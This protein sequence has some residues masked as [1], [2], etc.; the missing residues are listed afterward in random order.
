MLC[1]L[2]ESKFEQMIRSSYTNNQP[3]Q[4]QPKEEEA[5]TRGIIIYQTE[6]NAPTSLRLEKRRNHNP[7][8]FIYSKKNFKRK[9][10]LAHSTATKLKTRT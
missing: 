1:C 5:V 7:Q 3:K 10:L 9:N 8:H 2:Q 6:K 4:A